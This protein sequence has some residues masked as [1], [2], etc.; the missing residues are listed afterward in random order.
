[1]TRG[2]SLSSGW[3][4]RG[5]GEIVGACLLPAPLDRP[6]LAQVRAALLPLAPGAADRLP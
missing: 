5:I 6:S 1:L 2:T 4:G 3:A